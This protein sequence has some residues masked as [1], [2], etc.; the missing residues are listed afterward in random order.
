MNKLMSAEQAFNYSMNICP[1]S[2]TANDI[3]K[4]KI[5]FYNQI[6]NVIGN[7]L[8]D[9]DDFINSYTITNNNIHLLNSF[10]TKYIGTNDLFWAYT[11][12][13][14]YGDFKF[15]V[16]DS[17]IQGLFTKDELSSMPQVKLTT[18]L[19]NNDDEWTPYPNFKKKYSLVWNVD[20]Y[21]LD[22]SWSL[23]AIDFYNHMKDFFNSDKIYNYHSAYPKNDKKM[24]SL[25]NDYESCFKKYLLDG[26]TTSDFHK[27]ISKAYEL[28]YSGDTKDFI[29]RRWN[30]EH[31]RILSFI[32]DTLS[33]LNLSISN[34]PDFNKKLKIK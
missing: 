34:H 10:D 30:I 12:V 2:Y 13:T 29:I 5:K 23:A 11:E 19:K 31:S 16:M 28:D 22:S 17:N 6:F 3:F 33:M 20:L 4:A 7:G 27:S 21:K 26:M 8:N 15:P 1:T 25:I 24:N 9:L 18:L 14:D 32:D